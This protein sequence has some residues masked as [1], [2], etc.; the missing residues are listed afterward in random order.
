MSNKLEFLMQMMEKMSMED[1]LQLERWMLKEICRFLGFGCGFIYKSEHAGKLLLFER[2]SLYEYNHL[3]DFIDCNAVFTQ[4]QTQTLKKKTIFF[5]A[6]T[7]KDALSIKLSEVFH[8]RSMILLS[9][10]NSDS[11]L[12][13]L[14]GLVDRRGQPRMQEDDVP[15]AQTLLTTLVTQTKLQMY[16]AKLQQLKAD[17]E[18]KTDRLASNL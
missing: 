7:P 15:F 3:L 17:W 1:S 13:G 18:S 11:D 8:A 2:Y 14:V 4:S 16:H 5:R 9:V 10:L 12:T 6:A